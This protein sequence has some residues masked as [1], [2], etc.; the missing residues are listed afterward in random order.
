[1]QTA[2]TTAM[3]TSVPTED[4]VFTAVMFVLAALVLFALAVEAGNY[5]KISAGIRRARNALRRLRNHRW[6]GEG[7]ST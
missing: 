2:Y 4:L 7:I 5:P 6:H 3:I 1:M